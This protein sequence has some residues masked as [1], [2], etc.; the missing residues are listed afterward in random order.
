MKK[1]TILLAAVL[2]ISTSFAQ[3]AKRVDN[4]HF[5][6]TSV[7]SKSLA[8]PIN[9]SK[10]VVDTLNYAGANASSIGTG[11]AATF[12]V[13]A[14]H[15]ATVMTPLVGNYITEV[16]FY[17]NG[18]TDVT[19]V[20]IQ[21]Y[22][23][24]TTA[25]FT[26]AVGTVVEG[27][28]TVLLSPSYPITA[29]KLYVGYE[30]VATGG[31]PAGVDAGPRD[32]SGNGDIMNF[33]SWTTL[34]ALAS[35]LDANWNIKAVVDD[36]AATCFPPTA[37]NYT[38]ITF[39]SADIAWTSSASTW[40]LKVSS[41]M[42]D[43]TTGTG[44]IFDG[45]ATTASYSATGLSEL[46]DYYVYVQTDCGATT[47]SWLSSSFITLKDCSAPITAPWLD[48]MSA[49]IDCWQLYDVDGDGFKW[50]AGEVVTGNMSLNSF[51]YDNGSSTA[52]TPDNWAVTNK[53]NIAN[54]T[55]PFLSWTAKSFDVDWAAEQYSVYISTT[56]NTPADFITAA[57]NET[58]VDDS[59]VYRN[60][61]LSSY[62]GDIWVAFRHHGVTDMYGMSID[63]VK[64]DN[65]ISI[66]NNLNSKVDFTIYPNPANDKVTIANA[67]NQK[68]VILDITGKVVYTI[69]NASLLQE[70]NT[71]DFAVGTYIV[72]VNAS[73]SKFTVN[74]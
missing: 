12:G 31:Y 43:P 30:L 17:I 1:I 34:N 13:Y 59:D 50:A 70:I 39:N 72:R 53:I 67:E 4:T 25:V 51:S 60:I 29:D 10:T 54:L 15:P 18:A 64:V 46:T 74:R 38:N 52:L 21:L 5:T 42:I 66:S 68:V 3:L 49:G 40:N 57:F 33:G 48:D 73:V 71:S 9:S 16:R 62:S 41:T 2:F 6:L 7:T 45:A 37:L 55:T 26:Q 14:L 44:D 58:L 22:N 61:D 24:T 36:A 23:D 69:E 35:T 8:S 19:S 28:N 65:T 20:E 56:G 47:S 11:G 32:V 63:N 27:W